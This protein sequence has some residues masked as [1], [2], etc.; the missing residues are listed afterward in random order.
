LSADDKQ[1]MIN[2]I[3]NYMDEW[4][5]MHDLMPQESGSKESSS[6]KKK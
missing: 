5:V 2:S 6:E 4:K 1:Q 3:H